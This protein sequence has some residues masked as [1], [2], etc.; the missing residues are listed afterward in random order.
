MSYQTIVGLE[1][2]V[3]LSTKTKA[4]CSCANEFGGEPNTRVCPTCLGLPGGLPVLNKNVVNYS[5]MAGL[6]LNCHI[7]KKSKFDRKNYFYPDLTKGF[8]ITQDDMAICSEGYLEIEGEEGLKKVGIFKV[9]MEEDTG[10]SLHTEDNETLMDYNRCGVPLIE[11]VSKPDMNSG[12]EARLFL[13][14]L[15]STLKY[16]GVSDVKMEEGSLRCDVN[17]NVI[18]K[19][20]NKKTQVTEVKN[21][22]S[23]RGAEKAID[24][25]VNRHIELLK[26]GEDEVKTTRRWDDVNNQTVLMRE[27]YTVADYRFAPEGDLLEVVLTDEWIN[28]IKDKL[29]ELPEEKKKRFIKDYKLPEY[30]AEV[31]TSSQ[32]LADYY[33]EVAKRFDDTAMI[34]NWIMTEILRRVENVEESFDLP[35]TPEDLVEL[36]QTIKDGKINNNAGKKVLREM[37]ETGKKPMAIIEEQGLIQ[38]SDTS[39]IETIVET[40]L[41]ENAQSIED[42]KAGKDR[43]F[44][45]LVGQVMKASR[46][47][48][49]PQVVNELLKKKLNS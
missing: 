25:E 33:E 20:T 5:V 2:H 11:I 42:Y 28:D 39:E 21:I 40:I 49:N 4:F 46:G 15:K 10:K 34:S 23:F 14:K 32:Q 31:L 30:D 1:I 24:F 17:V 36:L 6:A 47:K 27:K 41:S 29:P 43:A 45:F 16:I 13:E 38:I 44:G 8:Q 26:N 19:T 18:D 9:Q 35:F 12:K 48:A 22:N 7:A 37:F 3:E